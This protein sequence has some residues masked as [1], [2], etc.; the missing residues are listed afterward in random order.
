MG[1]YS[2]K[3]NIR[4]VKCTNCFKS[5]SVPSRMALYNFLQKVG[6]ATVGELVGQVGLTQP[7]VSYHLKEMKISGLL[8]SEKIGKEVHYAIN[9]MCPHFDQECILHGLKFPETKVI[10]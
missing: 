4:V 9:E 6:D 5:V 7:T 2:K 1:N 3:L 8:K 10:S